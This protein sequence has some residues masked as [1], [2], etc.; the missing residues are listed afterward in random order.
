MKMSPQW[1]KYFISVLSSHILL[2][3]PY[4]TGAISKRE[5]QMKSSLIEHCLLKCVYCDEMTI[6]YDLSTCQDGC[7]SS[8]GAQVDD[9]CMIYEDKLHFIKTKGQ[10]SRDHHPAI[11]KHERKV[12]HRHRPK[13]PKKTRGRHAKNQIKLKY[14][15]KINQVTSN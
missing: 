1:F 8:G 2:Y 9:G 6:H 11:S 15:S 7:W 5:Q 3:L 12:H 14:A 4:S 10:R 13:R